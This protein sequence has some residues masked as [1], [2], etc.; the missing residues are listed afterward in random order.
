MLNL[1]PQQFRHLK[2]LTW[3]GVFAI[4]RDNEASNPKWIEHYTSR[5]YSSW[6]EWRT[7]THAP[8]K[9][10]QLEWH[11]YEVLDPLATIPH[12]RGGPF[13]SW[14][15]MYFEG[16]DS[17][18]F[19]DLVQH[20]GLQHHE[21]LEA[22]ITD[23]PPETTISGLLAGGDVYTIEGMHRCCAIALAAE[24]GLTLTTELKLILA[25]FPQATLPELGSLHKGE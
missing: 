22:L 20:P 23:F 1:N 21:G 3:E 2:P 6:E 25:E 11:L 5:G 15:R 16:K 9:G 7:A 8:I 10:S 4:W 12:F 14:K 19:A 13:K 24:R 18:R 17:P